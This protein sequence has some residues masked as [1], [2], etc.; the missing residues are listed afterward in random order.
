MGIAATGEVLF[1]I[2]EQA[3]NFHEF[4]SLFL[5]DLHCNEALY[6]DGT[7]SGLFAPAFQRNDH[8]YS[9]GPILGIVQQVSAA[10][11]AR[12]AFRVSTKHSPAAGFR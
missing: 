12:R 5:D 11:F 6:F 1:A 2:S 4:A 7:V 9:L 10:M 8:R 3:V